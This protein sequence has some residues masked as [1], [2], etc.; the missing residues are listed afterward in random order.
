AWASIW[1][2]PQF[3]PIGIPTMG[4]YRE[5]R[6][7]SLRG[8]S[9]A[10]SFDESVE[11]VRAAADGG[12]FAAYIEAQG[13]ANV[14]RDL[15]TVRVAREIADELNEYDEEVP[16]VVGIFAPH[17]GES[18]IHKTRETQWRIVSKAVDVDLD[19]LTLKSASGA[20]RSPVNNCGAGQHSVDIKPAVTP[21]EYA[22]AVIKLIE[23]G[24]A[25][26]NDPDVAK[27]M[28]DTAKAQSP[29]VSRHQRSADPYKPR[30]LA[31]SARLTRIERD[32]TWQISRDLAKEGI[33]AKRWELEA[34][35]RG[36]TVHLDEKV[37]T[38]PIL[39]EWRD[40]ALY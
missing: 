9:I 5:C 26:W 34:L 30:D 6:R 37:F 24:D 10:D 22:A 18:H 29:T 14:A 1:R 3:H 20:P 4:A 23:S 39:D 13:G 25:S 38:Y 21:S 40:N 12:D 8:I 36:A 19:P 17:L 28:R 27:V 33:T 7:Q 32:R 15:Q 11:A 2:I 31:P 35:V 16:K